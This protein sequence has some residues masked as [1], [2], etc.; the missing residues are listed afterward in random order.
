[1]ARRTRTLREMRLEYEAAEA[2]GLIREDDKPRR[3][4]GEP[5]TRER[6][7]AN[8]PVARGRMKVVWLVCD[9]GGRTVATF[10]YPQKADAEALM[11]QL[12]A[13]GKGNHF[14]RSEKVP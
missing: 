10:D 13:K 6:K 7:P 8:K 14:L 2:R 12:K 1:M 4:A 3:P 11:A 9:L 5:S